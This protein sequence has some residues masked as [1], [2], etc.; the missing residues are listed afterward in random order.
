MSLTNKCHA[1]EVVV[2]EGWPLRRLFFGF[3]CLCA[4]VELLCQVLALLLCH[5]YIAGAA[6]H[7]IIMLLLP[8][9]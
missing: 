7:L 1:A 2:F 4:S 5:L 3:L 8:A 9:D 6:F